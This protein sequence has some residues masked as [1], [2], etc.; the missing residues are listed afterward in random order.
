MT[1]G[2][3]TDHDCYR[4][5][6]FIEI[7]GAIE[8][9]GERDK[10][11]AGA[12]TELKQGQSRQLEALIA[13]AEQGRRIDHVRS[14]LDNLAALMRESRAAQTT[15][16]KEIFERLNDLSSVPKGLISIEKSF[17]DHVARQESH[18]RETRT[19]LCALE[20]APGKTAEEILKARKGEQSNL[21]VAVIAAVIIVII[22]LMIGV[23]KHVA[24][25]LGGG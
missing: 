15:V 16:D 13:I 19:R 9:L 21:R 24:D 20:G 7:K 18:N 8:R 6:L 4:E 17:T 14:D 11:L 10:N 25:K 12:L 5:P 22:E 3:E 1:K 23:G 2:A